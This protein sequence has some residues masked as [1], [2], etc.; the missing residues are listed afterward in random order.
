MVKLADRATNLA[1]PPAYWTRAKK[2]SYRDEA[3]A[4]AAALGSA[5]PA[6]DARLR[7]R[8]ESYAQY[9]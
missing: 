7:G 5:C 8:I 9:F 4:I 1:P 6:L 3:R 2:E